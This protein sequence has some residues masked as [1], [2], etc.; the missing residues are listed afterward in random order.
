[1]ILVRIMPIYNF[2]LPDKS[3]YKELVLTSG[4]LSKLPSLISDI[5]RDYTEYDSA[6]V[7][8]FDQ[9]STAELAKYTNI[10]N[11][12]LS[13]RKTNVFV[14]ESAY[15]DKL[16]RSVRGLEVRL[17]S[18]DSIEKQV[19]LEFMLGSFGVDFV[20]LDNSVKVAK[21]QTKSELLFSRFENSLLDTQ[22]QHYLVL[23]EGEFVGAFCLAF[24]PEIHQIQLHSVAGRAEVENIYS[25]SGKMSLIL[26]AVVQ[27]LNEYKDEYERLLFTCS[28][29]KIARLYEDFGFHKDT[30]VMI[31][32][33]SY[34]I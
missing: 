22:N 31:H 9:E 16:K 21:N 18:L 29:P 2:K 10:Y 14:Q 26:Q 11:L 15:L 27:V 23:K 3:R 4:E 33:I 5:L 19:Y 7:L 30:N 28:K 17:I 12:L 8:T 32:N 20:E 13:P 25:G 34:M 24:L 6:R 1:M